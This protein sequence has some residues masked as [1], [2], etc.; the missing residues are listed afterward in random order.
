MQQI[1][2]FNEGN[3]VVSFRSGPISFVAPYYTA[4][5]QPLRDTM[6]LQDPVSAETKMQVVSTDF[7]QFYNDNVSGLDKNT[8]RRVEAGAQDTIIVFNATTGTTTVQ[9]P[10]ESTS[11]NRSEQEAYAIYP[12]GEEAMQKHIVRNVRYPQEAISVK[13]EGVVIVGFSLDA[14]GK[15]VNAHLYQKVHPA[16][17]KEALRVVSTLKPFVIDGKHSTIAHKLYFLPIS[18]VM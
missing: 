16:I 17:D 5:M 6:Y 12:G 7:M 11:A 2:Q 3:H 13:K 8:T 4:A 15:I 18:F 10:R 9:L 14:N 1:S